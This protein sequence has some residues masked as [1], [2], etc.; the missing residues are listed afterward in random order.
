MY[1]APEKFH[2]HKE[3]FG[4]LDTTYLKLFEGL[5]SMSKHC[6]LECSCKV[7]NNQI[8]PCRF[9]IWYEQVADMK[10]VVDFIKSFSRTDAKLNLTLLKRIYNDK[11]EL[12]SI[13]KMIV[14]IDLRQQRDDSRLKF[15]LITDRNDYNLF[16]L[17]M[18]MYGNN[19]KMT[20]LVIKNE[21]LF[22]F[23]F[24][25]NN[26]TKMKIY[27]F[28]TSYELRNIV[29]REKLKRIFS[30]ATNNLI[31]KCTRLYISFE[32]E[33]CDRIIHFEIAKVNDFLK[34]INNNQLSQIVDRV[35][36]HM[37]GCIISLR[38]KEIDLG[39]IHNFNLYY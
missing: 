37:S 17:V 7:V 27:P 38:E 10:M 18:K 2:R 23:D 35:R 20:D 1:S 28:F 30:P 39:Q 5:I 13:Q 16:N 22:G 32:G 4:I 36:K 33:N 3:L 25:L 19:E 14:G 8:F 24:F 29:I 26:T 12:G 31:S 15:W 9:N 34:H 11:I 21:I 6:S